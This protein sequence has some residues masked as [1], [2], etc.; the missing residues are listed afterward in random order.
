[1]LDHV[2]NFGPFCSRLSVSNDKLSKCEF[3]GFTWNKRF[4]RNFK[5]VELKAVKL[6]GS[7]NIQDSTNLLRLSRLSRKLETEKQVLFYL[8][9]NRL[10]V[11]SMQDITRL[12]TE[13]KWHRLKHPRMIKPSDQAHLEVKIPMFPLKAD[14]K[15][16]IY[17]GI[18]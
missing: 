4:V 15:L 9:I 3:L 12:S 10:T 1:M 18:Q 14:H 11:W 7:V 16:Q 5:A 6:N 17:R 13:A 8:K 2:A